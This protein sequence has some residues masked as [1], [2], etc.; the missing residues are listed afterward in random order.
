MKVLALVGSYNQDGSSALL[1]KE[2][3]KGYKQQKP[4]AEVKEYNIAR[5]GIEGCKGCRA[6]VKKPGF[7][8]S[9]DDKASEII[10]ELIASDVIAFA[11]PVYY[12]GMPGVVKNF[13]DR[14][15][16]IYGWGTGVLKDSLR[17]QFK[18]KKFVGIVQCAAGGSYCE[19]SEI[20]LKCAADVCLSKYYPLHIGGVQGPKILDKDERKKKR[21][22]DL[23]IKVASE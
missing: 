19:M 4:D 5:I 2:F 6:C 15:F 11:F 8:C 13:I 9:L 14:L 20:P 3:L 1:M 17:E 21:A 18:T 23:G 22:V 7:Y 10:K 12:Y 16:S